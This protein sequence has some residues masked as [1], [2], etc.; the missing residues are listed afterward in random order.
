ME[1]DGGYPSWPCISF[2]N[3]NEVATEGLKIEIDA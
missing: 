2:L 3:S 1:N